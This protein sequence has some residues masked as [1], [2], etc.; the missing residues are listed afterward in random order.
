M[1]GIPLEA[2]KVTKEDLTGLF[3]T[4]EVLQKW[5]KGEDAEWPPMDEGDPMSMPELRFD[6][7]TRV[8]CRIGPNA[9]TDWAP[10]TISQ[11][12]YKEPNWPPNSFAPYQIKLDDGRSIFAPADLDQVIR[13]QP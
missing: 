9:E 4:A 7:G 5:H 12:W 2:K 13:K 11:L 3:P 10:G 1:F 8:L 6:M